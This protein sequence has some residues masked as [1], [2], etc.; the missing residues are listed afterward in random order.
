[1]NLRPFAW[2]APLGL[3][4]VALAAPTLVRELRVQPDKNQ[5]VSSRLAGAWE[6]DPALG[7]RLGTKAHM[8]RLEFTPD[9]SVLATIPAELTEKITADRIY[10]AGVLRFVEKGEERRMPYLLI[11][12][13]GNSMVCMYPSRGGQGLDDGESMLLTVVPARDTVADLLFL[14][15]DFN[16]EPFKAYRRV[17]K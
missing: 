11:V 2:L 3:T 10:Q 14:G 8:E 12:R 7:E 17:A 16:N 15:G 4:A 1:M 9:E 5:V 13:G 6:P